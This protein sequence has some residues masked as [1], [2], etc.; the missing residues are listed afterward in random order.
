MLNVA[1]G[2]AG[3]VQHHNDCSSKAQGCGRWKLWPLWS[4]LPWQDGAEERG[5]LHWWDAHWALAHPL[6]RNKRKKLLMRGLLMRRTLADFFQPRV[7]SSTV[8]FSNVS[9]GSCAL[10][11]CTE[12]RRRR[13]RGIAPLSVDVGFTKE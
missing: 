6:G 3:S 11:D 2:S 13:W 9:L 8:R 5:A 10:E 7:L 12:S 4:S 1:G